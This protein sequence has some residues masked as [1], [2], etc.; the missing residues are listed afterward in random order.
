[1]AARPLSDRPPRRRL[2]LSLAFAA[3]AAAGACGDD[4][5]PVAPGTGDAAIA[6]TVAQLKTGAG[7]PN[8]VVVALRDGV[9]VRAAATGADGSFAFDGLAPGDYRVRLT[10]LELSGLSLSHT[11]F[12]PLEQAAEVAAG[13]TVDLVFV[14]VGVIPPR[15]Q[16]TVTCGGLP[17][18][19]ARVRLVGGS[20]D[21]TVTTDGNGQFG[22]IDLTEGTYAV[23]P[24]DRPCALQPAFRVV[25]VR[26]SGTVQAEFAG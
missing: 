3:A 19:G 15:I 2:A 4:D 5:E 16:G 24:V 17:V 13:A 10:G 14:A 22:T 21:V 7:V 20:S 25:E 8:V 26:K 11:I 1:M 23:I 9:V 18:S 6:G 12:D